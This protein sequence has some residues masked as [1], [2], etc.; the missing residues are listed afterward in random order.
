MSEMTG[1]K[2]ATK[3]L[4]IRPT[5]PIILCTGFNEDKLEE[6]AFSI[7]IKKFLMKP[8]DILTIK[9]SVSVFLNEPKIFNAKELDY[10]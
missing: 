5:L 10:C 3:L 9:N 6:I 8:I 7:G 4:K 1:D 2:V